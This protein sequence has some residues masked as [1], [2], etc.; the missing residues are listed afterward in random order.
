MRLNPIACEEP[1]D[2][3][4]TKICGE[5]ATHIATVDGKHGVVFVCERHALQYERPG[6]RVRAIG[7]EPRL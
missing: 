3:S 5:A 1:K 6:C 4:L 2:E 7:S